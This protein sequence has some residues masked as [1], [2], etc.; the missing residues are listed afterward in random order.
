MDKILNKTSYQGPYWHINNPP[1]SASYRK[2]KDEHHNLSSTIKSS[3]EEEIVFPK[4]ARAI[5]TEVKLREK[6]QAK[7]REY[8][9]VYSNTEQSTGVTTLLA[10]SFG[11][12]LC[13]NQNGTGTP[14]PI[15]IENGTIYSE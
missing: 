14:R 4:P 6:G 1:T 2:R 7:R 3:R 10:P 13:N 11:K 5:T 15:R 12:N 8:G 9:A